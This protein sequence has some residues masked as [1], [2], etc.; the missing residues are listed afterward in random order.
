MWF[1]VHT[2]AFT[3]H[4]SAI[5]GNLWLIEN[6]NSD[7]GKIYNLGGV[8]GRNAIAVRGLSGASDLVGV[9][10]WS[11]HITSSVCRH[12]KNPLRGT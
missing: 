7:M 12:R 1:V 6:L 2:S 4:K 9:R 3:T 10:L 5:P 8:F 11:I